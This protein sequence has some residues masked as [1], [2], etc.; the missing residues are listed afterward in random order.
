[1]ELGAYPAGDGSS[2]SKASLHA[3]LRFWCTSSFLTTQKPASW[4]SPAEKEL[5]KERLRVEGSK[6]ESASMTW[7]DTKESGEER[8]MFAY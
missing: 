1:M 6:C 3:H 4:L 2:S 7:K 8:K 5:A